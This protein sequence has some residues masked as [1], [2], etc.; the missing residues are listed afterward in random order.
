MKPI[1]TQEL[2]RDLEPLFLN[3]QLSPGMSEVKIPCTESVA[4]FHQAM[5]D[6]VC[7]PKAEAKFFIDYKQ[8]EYLWFDIDKTVRFFFTLAFN[9]GIV[10]QLIDVL[11]D[12]DIPKTEIEEIEVNF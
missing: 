2:T 10:V 1:I 9:E 11:Y 4:R 12:S 6:M 3:F 7:E 5:M 8:V